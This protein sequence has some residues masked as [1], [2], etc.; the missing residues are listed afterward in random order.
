VKEI[1]A[2]YHELRKAGTSVPQQGADH[3]AQELP[4]KYFNC[5]IIAFHIISAC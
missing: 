2:M 3:K 5:K 1:A 4:H